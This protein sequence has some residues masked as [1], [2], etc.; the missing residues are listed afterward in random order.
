ML[1]NLVINC[2]LILLDHYLNFNVKQLKTGRHVTLNTKWIAKTGHL[3]YKDI[4]TFK[5]ESEEL[6][7]FKLD[8]AVQNIQIATVVNQIEWI[9]D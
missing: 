8:A 3:T 9:P 5:L 7:L 4:K 2:L 1:D 6:K